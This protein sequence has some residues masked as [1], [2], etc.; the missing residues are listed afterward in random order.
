MRLSWTMIR[1][2]PEDHH[3]HSI[4]RCPIKCR[5]YVTRMRVDD[6][7]G[8]DFV[9]DK[10]TEIAEIRFLKLFP[11][12]FFPA[13]MNHYFS[14]GVALSPRLCRYSSIN[15]WITRDVSSACGICSRTKSEASPAVL[16]VSDPY[17]RRFQTSPDVDAR[18]SCT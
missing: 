4:K 15:A 12:S 8:R 16:I 1:V 11:Q 13:R 6:L 18:T 17:R 9:M 5:K 7:S 3:P 10:S 2:L 14:H